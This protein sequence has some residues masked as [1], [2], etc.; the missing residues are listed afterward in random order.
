MVGEDPGSAVLI[1]ALE[2]TQGVEVMTK[3][4]GLADLR[5]LCA[6]PGRLCQALAVSGEHSGL[7]AHRA[8]FDLVPGGVSDVIA[9]PRIGISKAIEVPWRFGEAGSRYLSKPFRV[10][11][12]G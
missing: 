11:P 2:P 4:R 12:A 3:R 1:R 10:S 8:P 6:G 7:A 9:G 5:L